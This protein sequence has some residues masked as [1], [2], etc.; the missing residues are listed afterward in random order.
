MAVFCAQ[1]VFAAGDNVSN[2]NIQTIYDMLKELQWDQSKDEN[3]KDIFERIGKLQE[4][5]DDDDD[6]LK[7]KQEAYEEAKANEQSL[8]NRTLT[9]VSTAATG[10][11]GMELARGLAEQNADKEADAN[12]AAYIATMRCTYADGKQVKAGPDQIELPGGNNADLMKYRTEYFALAKDLKERKEALGMKPGIESEEII[13]KTQTGLYDDE[14]L[15]I[16]SG[17]YASLYRAQMLGS[18]AD[19]A[20]IDE[21]RSASKKRVI[22]GAIAA[23]VGV[24]GGIVGNFLI[25]GKKTDPKTEREQVVSDLNDIMQEIIKECNDNLAKLKSAPCTDAIVDGESD[26]C[27]ERKKELDATQP[28]KD[29]SEIEKI[30]DHPACR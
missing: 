11:G 30:K 27:A 5:S 19:Q 8:A 25:N 17:A 14:S 10:I 26:S 7:E 6:K 13:D 16:D 2:E 21:E 28:I 24:I 22:G 15:S 9:A 4:N 29:I 1:P 23:G 18:E 3:R 12:M 20:K